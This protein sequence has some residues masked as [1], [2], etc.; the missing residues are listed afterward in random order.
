[1]KTDII[2][3]TNAILLAGS[4]KSA[5]EGGLKAYRIDLISLETELLYNIPVGN[6]SYITVSKSGTIYAVTESDKENS[7]LT[8]IN[9]GQDGFQILNRVKIAADSP[10]HIA[11]TPDQRFAITAN[12]G[13][14][15][16]SIFPIMNDGRAGE[17][18]HHLIFKGHG[19]FP[20]RQECSRIHCI[21]FTPDGSYMLVNDLGND[22]IY[23]FKLI[24]DASI[25]IGD[26]PE[27]TVRLKSG[28]GPRHI[29]FGSDKDTAY[30]INEISDS[31]TVLR[32]DGKTLVPV[33]Y[34]CANKETAH[35]AGDISLSQD[36]KFI[37]ASLRLK[38][39][40]LA[41]FK[42]N[43]CDASLKYISHTSTGIHPRNIHRY[44]NL[45]FVSCKD[46][47]K[48]EIYTEFNG[49]LTLKKSISQ[50]SVVFSTLISH[51]DIRT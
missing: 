39:D 44:K 26:T 43:P 20:R 32:Y 7:L 19:L 41:T 29:I 3:A 51:K 22:S 4:Y 14:G 16:V 38:N 10:C 6:A 15:S 35:G 45:L 13:D 31:V 28:S 5:D 33:Q 8:A 11:L 18:C 23:G 21:Q 1:M 50:A 9:I 17:C 48:I 37:F 46:S 40:G 2:S 49:I 30:L 27:F 47:D 42:I 25:P 36:G 34:I 24:Q 12:Y